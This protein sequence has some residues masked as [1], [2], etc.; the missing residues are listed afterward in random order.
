MSSSN[1]LGRILD[2]ITFAHKLGVGFEA[3]FLISLRR[4]DGLK[5][6]KY[7][8]DSLVRLEILFNKSKSNVKSNHCF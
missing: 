6:L 1:G 3:A 4:T 7:A 5:L 8:R 2:F